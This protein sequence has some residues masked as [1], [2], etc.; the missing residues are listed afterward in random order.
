MNG[1]RVKM[2]EGEIVKGSVIW[3]ME[4]GGRGVEKER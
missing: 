2:E 3:R 4:K 1:D